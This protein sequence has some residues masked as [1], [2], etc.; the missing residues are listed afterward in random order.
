MKKL[1]NYLVMSNL[2]NMLTITRLILVIPL[3]YFIEFNKNELIFPILIIGSLTDYLDGYYAKK[4]N[5]KT[6][7]GAII[8]P[9]ADKI[10]T[11]I[12]L[13]WLCKA[14]I[15]PYWSLSII[16]FRE[17]I[18]SAFRTSKKDGLPASKMAKIKTIFIFVSIILFFSPIKN[19]LFNYLGQLTYWIGFTLT[20]TTGLGY[21]RIKK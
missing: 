12:P 9:A 8:D 10:F 20:L 17:F 18:V 4:L 1:N 11:I 16:I 6:T 7:F 14:N 15:I 19:E 13:V 2:P 21:L 5:L 3:I